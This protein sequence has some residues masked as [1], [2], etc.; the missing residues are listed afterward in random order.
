[1]K[2]KINAEWDTLRK[3]AVHSPGI[4]MYFGLL[5][6]FASL[7]ERSFSMEKAIKEHEILRYILKHEFKINVISLKEKLLNLADKSIFIR[8]KLMDLANKKISYTGDI[9][10]VKYA[11]YE[12][13]KNRDILDSNYYFNS[14]LLN[15][16]VKLESGIGTRMI[17]LH[18]TENEPLSN[19]YFMRDQQ[20][21]T[22]RGIII[23]RMSKPQRMREPEITKF[24]WD[25]LN[26]PVQCE[27]KNPGT[28][29][30]GDFIPMDNFALIGVGDRTNRAG[31]EQ[32]LKNGIGYSEVAIVH[33]PTHPL[34]TSGKT[35]YMMNMHLD[36]YFNV[37]SDGVVVGCDILL[38]NAEVEVYQK[39]GRGEYSKINKHTNLHDYI[40]SKGF[41]IID[42]TTLEYLAYASNFLCVKNGTI[43]SVE[44]DRLVKG[45][46]NNLEKKASVDPE[47][48]VDLLKQVKKDYKFLQSEGQFF[49]HK[50]EIYQHDIDAY[51]L[52]LIN[53]TGG[54]GG[55]H[56]M[57]C[58]L[59]RG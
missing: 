11:K 9:Y 23:S 27:V 46:I 37:A 14:L 20:A 10:E 42:I 17:Q 6:P 28:F 39:E 32:I 54:Y 2:A 43:I 58:A 13:E 48:Y 24:L 1:M 25:S 5:D 19:L 33:Q 34:L 59:K 16:T 52:N 21:V 51:P 36:T 15:P 49:P 40:I 7:Y 41:E 29:E 3:V 50:K 18:V 57:T 35:D 56:C 31:I 30:G 8:E 45:V 4:E 12:S 44:V 38:K 53:L 47:T 55:A 22:D 26:I